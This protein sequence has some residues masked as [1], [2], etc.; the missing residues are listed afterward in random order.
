MTIQS[1]YA[2]AQAREFA[3]DFQ[4]RILNLGPFVE[5]DLLYCRTANLPG[6]EITN[7]VVPWMG[8]DFNIPGSVKYTGSNA[9]T[10]NFWCDEGIN[11]RNKVENWI[12]E[13]FNDQTSTGK[14]GVPI[15][16]ASMGLLDKNLNVI[17]KYDFYG[18]YC[19]NVG[20]LAYNIEG[21]GTVVTFDATFAYQ[22]WRLA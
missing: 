8:L 21:T 19:Q 17:R 15:E 12:T 7:Q 18:V 1:F 5:N 2:A 11:V 16:V 10:L 4:F 14:Y 20:N 13:I 22:F 6:K 9:W 3:R